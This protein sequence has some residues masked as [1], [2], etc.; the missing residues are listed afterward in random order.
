MSTTNRW[1]KSIS[2]YWGSPLNKWIDL[3][4]EH[5]F[6]SINIDCF[7]VKL[8]KKLMR[9]IE[10]KHI[11]EK[12]Q[13]QQG[14]ALRLLAGLLKLLSQENC[15]GWQFQVCILQGD[16]PFIRAKVQDLTNNNEFE[17]LG[18]QQVKDWIE[19]KDFPK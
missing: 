2:A 8:E 19:F 6:T 3:N 16:E 14:K 1:G 9:F 12:L 4:C 13:E 11:N 5:N 18:F 15:G 7:Q 17:L 10:Y